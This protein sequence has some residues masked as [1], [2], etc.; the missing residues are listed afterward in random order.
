MRR[1]LPILSIL[2]VL[3]CT[4]TTQEPL[5]TKIDAILAAHPDQ[6]IAIAWTELDE[7]RS[8]LRNE[9]EIFHAA[10]TMKVPVMLGIFEAISRG[11][12]RLDQ[13]VTVRNRFVSI[14]DASGYALDPDSDSDPEIYARVGTEMPLEELVRRMIVL[15]SNLAT[16]LTIEL[17]GAPRVM[18]LMKEIGAHD[19]QVLRGVED[20]KAFDAGMNNTTTAHDL[21]QIFRT[22]AEGRVISPD[23]SAK[24]VEIL[25]AQEHRQG[26]PAGVPAGT[27]VAHKTGS[28]TRISHDAGIIT[29][30]DGSRYVLVVLTRGFED[31]REAQRVIAE[32]SRVVWDSR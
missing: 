20:Q 18:A 6:T 21:M 27:S 22:L 8:L 7:E 12:L 32:V 30:P 9:R 19:V 13:S 14:Y 24:M 15:S 1:M 28:I 23:A 11:D 3:A 25:L 17:I 29:R 10:S 2:F 5:A 31:G 26:I 16:N 4:T